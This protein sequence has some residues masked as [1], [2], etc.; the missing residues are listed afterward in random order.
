M[1]RVDAVD[2]AAAHSNTLTTHPFT[3]CPSESALPYPDPGATCAPAVLRTAR[4]R[5]VPAAPL[6][7]RLGVVPVRFLT[8]RLPLP[9]L[10]PLRR[11]LPRATPAHTASTH[12]RTTVRPR[13]PPAQAACDPSTT[14]SYR[15]VP[16]VTVD[17]RPPD[18]D[19]C[20][21]YGEPGAEPVRW[22]DDG[23]G[24]RDLALGDR[25]R[26]AAAARCRCLRFACCSA[27]ATIHT[28]THGSAA[29]TRAG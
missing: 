5:A 12:T 18:G 17:V 23:D 24:D 20:A 29:V 26:R 27:C 13:A 28:H 8:L 1:G 3:T 11:T 25:D 21:E 4:R 22:R 16:V 10:P 19:P 15:L 6:L 2:A 9:M 14:P 7:P